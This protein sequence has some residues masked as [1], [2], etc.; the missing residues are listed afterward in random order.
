M[1]V[2]FI[3]PNNDV[4]HITYPLVK[5]LQ[6][7]GELDI[8]LVTSINRFSS[9]YYNDKF[10]CDPRYL[11]FQ[12]ENRISNKKLRQILK[13]IG[14]SFYNLLLLRYV[15][16]DPPDIIHYNWIKIPV[17]DYMFIRIFKFFRIKIILTKHNYYPH[18]KKRL[19]LLE[20]RV[21]NIVEKIICLSDFVKHQFREDIRYKVVLIEHGNCYEQ[22]IGFYK[23]QLTKDHRGRKFKILFSGIIKKYK[24]IELLLDSIEILAN[25]SHQDDIFVTI[26]GLCSR[27]YSKRI[28][29]L[30]DEKKINQFVSFRPGF[31]SNWELYNLVYNSDIGVLPYLEATQSGIPYIYFSFQKPIVVTN[32]GAL[33]HQVSDKISKV[34]EPNAKSFAN[35]I[36]ELRE[37]VDNNQIAETDFLE[38]L[39]KF[40]WTDITK[41][42][43]QLYKEVHALS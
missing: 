16:K 5:S 37:L 32:V 21:L 31:L 17:I 1:K 18:S 8:R 12:Y 6:D 19:R 24:G 23:N 27:N 36:L 4:P 35:A 9:K 20:H 41:K 22:D 14:Y 40:E 33:P 3:D 10:W 38:H 11:F 29:W 15:F 26:V 2:L 39:K 30:I 28:E 43:I 34:A 25:E 42:Y 13:A 7:S